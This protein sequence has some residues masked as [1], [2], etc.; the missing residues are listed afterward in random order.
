MA[1]SY[2]PRVVDAELGSRLEFAGAV[3]IEGPKACGKTATAQ[4]V[5]STVFRLDTDAGARSLVSSAPEALFNAAT[6]ILFDEWQVTPKLWNLIRREVDDR[7]PQRGLFLLAGSATP[8][9]DADRHTGAGRFSTLRM[10]PMSLFE[11]GDSTGQVSVEDLFGGGFSPALDP[12]VPVSRLIDRMVT[13]GWPDLLDVPVRLAQQWMR[14]YLRTIVEV[15]V[16]QL[17]TRRHPENLRRLLVALA[18]G[19]G[20]ETTL[21]TLAADVG[22]ASGTADRD[23]VGEYLEALERLMLIEDVPAWAPHMR[24]TTPLRKSATRFMTDPSLAVAALG[25]GPAELLADLNATGFHFEGLVVRDLRAY[26]QP[27]GGR[28][29]H[30]RDNNGH[31]VDVIITLDDGRWA[32]L[33]VKMN[34]DDVDN[35]A[36]SLLRFVQK[37]D[38]VKVGEPAFLGVVTTRAAAARRPDGVLVLPVATLGP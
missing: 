30:W 9:D 1:K 15:D 11:S 31:E 14:D 26:S 23:T 21:K 25:V 12:G 3:L 5:A 19:V 27:L 10:R 4:R 20:T 13:G 35:A 32:A 38:T 17:G 8:N 2:L 36:G 34:P 22:G 28:L 6:P 24:S 16:Q 29:A 33:E 18:R 37:V 7:S